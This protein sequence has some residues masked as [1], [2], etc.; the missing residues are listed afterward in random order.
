MKVFIT[1]YALT[2]GIKEI[3]VEFS[4]NFPTMVTDAKN[5]LANYHKPDWHLQKSDA[6]KQ[7][8]KMRQAKIISLEKRLK[9]LKD[10]KF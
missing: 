4:S 1:Q 3:E 8:E 10:M 2:G 9:K 7:A 5:S 6:L